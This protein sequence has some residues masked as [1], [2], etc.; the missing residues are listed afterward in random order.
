MNCFKWFFGKVHSYISIKKAIASM[1]W[2]DL[3]VSGDSSKD[4][5][6]R[7]FTRKVKNRD[8]IEKQK[9]IAVLRLPASYEEYVSGKTKQSLRTNINK[10]KKNGY[11]CSFFFG[12]EFFDDIMEINRSSEYRGGRVMEDRYTDASLVKEF[13]NTDPLL[14]G[15]FTSEGKLISYIHVLRINALLITNKILGHSDY[16]DNGLMYFMISQFVDTAI[17]MSEKATY[18]MY[19]F[20]LVGRSHAGYQYFKERCGFK[21]MNIRFHFHCS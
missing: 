8:Y 2:I 19:G 20:F 16:L 4:I 9:N 7:L 21:G 18:I 14:F 11:Y 1:E 6:E 3:D 15:A 13:L 5:Y 10:A 12:T 17:R